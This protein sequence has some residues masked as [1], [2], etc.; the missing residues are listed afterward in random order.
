MTSHMLL[1]HLI[2]S[3]L[4]H[5]LDMLH[6]FPLHIQVHLDLHHNISNIHY[7]TVFVDDVDR[8]VVK[9]VYVRCGYDMHDNT[10]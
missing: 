10:Q 5:V 4:V 2:M 7:K 6:A 3:V 1:I 9:I 8:Y